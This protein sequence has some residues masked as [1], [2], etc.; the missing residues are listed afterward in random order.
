MRQIKAYSNEIVHK[1]QT[2]D[3]V[4]DELQNKETK[5]SEYVEELKKA[6][7]IEDKELYQVKTGGLYPIS[8]PDLS[9][10]PSILP[11]R[12]GTLPIYEVL[13]RVGDI[14]IAGISHFI[15]YQGHNLNGRY[16]TN[17]RILYLKDVPSDATIINAVAISFNSKSSYTVNTY[18]NKDKKQHF[19]LLAS[20]EGAANLDKNYKFE[21]NSGSI[22]VLYT[23]EENAVDFV[24]VQYIIEDNSYYYSGGSDK[25]EES[26]LRVSPV[27]ARNEYVSHFSE[28]FVNYMDEYIPDIIDEYIPDAGI[29]NSDLITLEGPTISTQ[30]G[31]TTYNNISILDHY[32]SNENPIIFLQITNPYL[33][34]YHST[35]PLILKEYEIQT[36]KWI[37]VDIE[38]FYKGLDIPAFEVQFY[39]VDVN[40]VDITAFINST[41]P[42]TKRDSLYDVWIPPFVMDSSVIS[43]YINSL[44]KFSYA[45]Y[46]RQ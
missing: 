42:D 5:D 17:Y 3:R 12:F 31:E 23:E 45:D 14:D 19:V 22:P 9:T 15:E 39:R 21:S 24:K 6:I 30:Y 38:A 2:L 29:Y 40:A 26:M 27:S 37:F 20:G 33:P 4:I 44:D 35:I 13:S 32:S 41:F 36:T 7:I 28:A 18:Y 34:P 11:Q 1:E 43:D 8:H 25:K 10:Q 46:I 16:A